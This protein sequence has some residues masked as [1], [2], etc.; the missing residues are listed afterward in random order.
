MR[1]GWDPGS[2]DVGCTDKSSHSAIPDPYGWPPAGQSHVV[3]NVPT[4]AGDQRWTLEVAVVRLQLPTV[5]PG[6][7]SAW[8]CSTS[9]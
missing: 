9:Q 1:K 2:A 5:V 3:Y 8:A 6:P 7:V 4:S